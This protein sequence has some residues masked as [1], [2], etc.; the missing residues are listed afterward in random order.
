MNLQNYTNKFEKYINLFEARSFVHIHFV[1][2][3]EKVSYLI[4]IWI[5][6][7]QKIKKIN[8]WRENQNYKC[9]IFILVRKKAQTVYVILTMYGF[10]GFAMNPPNCWFWGYASNPL[11]CWLVFLSNL[12]HCWFAF[13][14][15]PSCWSVICVKGAE[16]VI[17]TLGLFWYSEYGLSSSAR[18]ECFSVLHYIILS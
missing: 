12:S 1:Y 6:K 3:N 4:N 7:K 14:L 11:S 15:N 8:K 13:P 10:W 2:Y 5:C 18:I 16:E 17:N 9:Y